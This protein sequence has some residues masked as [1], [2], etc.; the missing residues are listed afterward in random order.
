MDWAHQG[1]AAAVRDYE[2]YLAGRLAA[3][4]RTYLCWLEEKRSPVSGE[5][6]P[7]L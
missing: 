5:R 7:D 2:S 4:L 6:L 3:D 1:M